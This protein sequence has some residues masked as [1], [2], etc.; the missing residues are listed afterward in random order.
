M[1]ESETYK[2]DGLI[3]VVVPVFN[4]AAWLR[5]ALLSLCA[6]TYRDFEAILIDDGSTEASPGICADFC[7]SDPRFSYFR[8]E[9]KGVSAARNRGI[10]LARGEWIFF[11]DA[12]D[13]VPPRSFETLV[14]A[15][16][17][18][19]CRIVAGHF[20]RD[21]SDS[22]GA[23]SEILNPVTLSARETIRIALYQKRILNGP[24]GTLFA[25]SIFAEPEP[26]R[27]RQCRYEDL[28]LFYR[29]FERVP[30]ICLIDNTTY[31][32][33]LNPMSFINT[34]SESR[35]DALDV[36]DRL[37]EHMQTHHPSLAEAAHDR[38]FSAHC[39]ILVTM[40]RHG[41]RNRSAFDR[42]ARVI[43][44][45]RAAE[46]RDPDVR[47]KNKLGALLSYPALPLISLLYK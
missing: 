35:L 26:L 12:D 5:D 33:R 47:I 42:C 20:S 30:S 29:A 41:V 11:L 44:E 22:P 46:L 24:W 39:N 18:S 34:W 43:R 40:L 28:D 4:A 17:I 37:L 2:T 38:R 19:G 25:R 32:Y 7:N 31:C 3:S 8:Q 9:N 13:T 45:R 1:T 16:R 15:S 14:S 23:G 10:D 21:V 27:F 36:T 6:Q